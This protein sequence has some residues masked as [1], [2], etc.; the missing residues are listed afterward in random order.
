MRVRFISFL[1]LQLICLNLTVDLGTYYKEYIESFGYKLEENPVITDDGYILSLWH[2][3]PKFPNGKTVFFQHGFTCTA[4]I[5]FHLGENSLPFYLLKEGY[6]IWLANNRGSYFSPGHISKDPKDPKSGYNNYSMDDFVASDMPAMVKYIKERTG[7]KKMT[8]I[9]HSQG[10]T[11]FL[12]A[13]MHDPIFTEESFDNFISLGTVPNLAHS[14]FLPIDILDMIYDLLRR[15]TFLQALNL[16]ELLRELLATLAKEHP[17]VFG[18]IFDTLASI[19]PSGR[20]DY[21]NIYNLLYYFPGGISKINLFHWSQIHQMK[22]LVYY[23]PNFHEEKTAKEYNLENLKK[24]K[25]KSLV[26]RSDDDTFG[27]YQDVTDFYD[28]VEDK[29]VIKL[30]ELTSYGHLDVL[31]AESAINDIFKPIIEFIK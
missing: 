11:L 18:K 12:M 14:K 29:S 7:A 22:K 8:F 26:T 21:I 31:F 23:N 17:K 9:G 16:P 20:M 25:I 15:A 2:L 10:T 27:S 24:W 1:L 30:L 13:M 19:Y 28:A 4:W 5:F 6:D 3:N